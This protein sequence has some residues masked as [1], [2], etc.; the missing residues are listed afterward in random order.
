MIGD[1]LR[2]NGICFLVLVVAYVIVYLFLLQWP[3][4][5]TDV[6]SEVLID[7]FGKKVAILGTGDRDQEEA[8]QSVGRLHGVTR[9]YGMRNHNLF[10][11]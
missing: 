1:F 9:M 3:D 5:Y 8:F 6:I 7:L 4:L 11:L 10:L 2:F